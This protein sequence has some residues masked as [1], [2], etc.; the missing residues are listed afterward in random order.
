M[1]KL[2]TENGPSQKNP[3]KITVLIADD[4]P[5]MRQALRNVLD[6][7]PDFNIVAEACDGAEA[8]RL[9]TELQPD[10]VIMDISMPK[11]NGLEATLQIKA[12][13]PEVAVLV[14]TV[15]DDIE[16]ILGILDAG[17][18]GYLTKS[19][20]GDDIVHAIRGVVTGECVF[21]S[22]ISKLI[23]KHAARYVA[24]PAS[25]STGEK[26]T[27]R[28]L[29]ILKLAAL[30]LSNR[31]IALKLDLSLRTIK[32]YLADIFS[33]LSVG[34]RTEAVITC[35]RTGLINMKDLE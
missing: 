3:E 24:K 12:K 16:H 21:S 8:I 18:A 10:V 27:T 32:G 19:V 5:L 22:S 31:D 2:S 20:F 25:L 35:L 13:C 23:L 11:I 1:E 7:Q 17:A 6:K 28:E 9:A 33:K 29:E 26:L 34:S 14:L 4:H 30:G 15:H